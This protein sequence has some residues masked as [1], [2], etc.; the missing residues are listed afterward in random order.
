M[1]VLTKDMN[2]HYPKT[3]KPLLFLVIRVS[4]NEWVS[5]IKNSRKT[6]LFL[7]LFRCSTACYLLRTSSICMQNAGM[8][9]SDIMR[10]NKHPSHMPCESDR[11]RN[12]EKID[13]IVKVFACRHIKC[14]MKGFGCCHQN[15]ETHRWNQLLKYDL[16]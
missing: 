15:Q 3:P 2:Y 9:I 11:S 10:S 16:Y 4:N 13:N 7:H 5:D 14:K 8:I 6:S 12:I 1:D